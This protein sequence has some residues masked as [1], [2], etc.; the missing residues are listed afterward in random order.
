MRRPTP[1]HRRS[2]PAFHLD[3]EIG[4][5]AARM[6]RL[7]QAFGR[8]RDARSLH[9]LKRKAVVEA[10]RGCGFDRAVL[11]S[12]RGSDL[13]AESAHFEGDPESAEEFLQVAQSERPHLEPSLLEAEIVRRRK[14]IL[15]EDARNDTRALE[16]FAQGILSTS[17]V[18]A[19]V[20]PEGHVV[21]ILHA[22][23]HFSERRLGQFDR[24]ILWAFAEAVGYIL[25]RAVLRE[26]LHLQRD[27]VSNLVSATG[28]M[29]SEL[30]AAQ[31]DLVPPDPQSTPMSRN[32]THAGW[33]A[34][35]KVEA[36]LTRRER[37]VLLLMG[38]GAT[39]AGIASRLVISESTVKSH[40]KQ[41]LR[42]LGAGNRGEAVSRYLL[43][44]RSRHGSPGGGDAGTRRSE[45]IFQVRSEGIV[46]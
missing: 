42:K 40:V 15:V 46:R 5:S 44:Q 31:I 33:T 16:L 14:P 10:C 25:E 38:A 30:A 11:F 18:A 23:C 29:L 1:E 19:P 12:I 45:E 43:A 36:D 3:G 32:G 7:R 22:D 20:M 39:N 34:N 27:N 13:V 41:I 2:A 26:R 28:G 21:G 4:E 8:L 37:E 35:S 24:D 6:S 9:Q 17:Y